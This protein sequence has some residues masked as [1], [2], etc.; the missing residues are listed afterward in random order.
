MKNINEHV[1]NVGFSF[2]RISNLIWYSD[3][4]CIMEF[5]IT[6]NLICYQ[7]MW[8]PSLGAWVYWRRHKGLG[9]LVQCYRSCFINIDFYSFVNLI[10]GKIYVSV[11]H[12]RVLIK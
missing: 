7:R 8:L 10:I 9:S 12:D 4:L 1:H 3:P 2:R 11:I 5:T 6:T